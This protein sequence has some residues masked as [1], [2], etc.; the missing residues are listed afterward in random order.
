[1][2]KSSLIQHI[3]AAANKLKDSKLKRR[4]AIVTSKVCTN[5]ETKVG[6]A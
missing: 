6:W 4:A 1:M 5:E 2:E 3:K